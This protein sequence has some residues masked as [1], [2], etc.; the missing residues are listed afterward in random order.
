MLVAV[1]LTDSDYKLHDP[2]TWTTELVTATFD[3]SQGVW[4]SWT[5]LTPLWPNPSAFYLDVRPE[6]SSDGSLLIFTRSFA[7]TTTSFIM[8]SIRG[9]DGTWAA[10]VQIAPVETNSQYSVDRAPSGEA[11]L[12]YA[13]RCSFFFQSYSSVSLSHPHTVRALTCMHS[14]A[15]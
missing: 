4:S 11:M 12:L 9:A 6:L 8:S 2:D 14:P 1:S 3:A 10:P 5:P 7:N 15:T 13:V